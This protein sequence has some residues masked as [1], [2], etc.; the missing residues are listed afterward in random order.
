MSNVVSLVAG[1]QEVE[2]QRELVHHDTVK[3]DCSDLDANLF[4]ASGLSAL[5]AS[6]LYAI[7]KIPDDVKVLTAGC[8]TLKAE[9]GAATIN[10]NVVKQSDFT[11][12]F[13]I[14]SALNANSVGDEGFWN[15]GDYVTV[16]A[17]LAITPN[18]ELDT[19]ILLVDIQYVRFDESIANQ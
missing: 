17:Y 14:D 1:R 8:R 7:L 3:I 5:A 16:P 11:Q 2:G 9:G 4:T 15:T 6:D 18:A 19:A 12:I 13:Q 10:V